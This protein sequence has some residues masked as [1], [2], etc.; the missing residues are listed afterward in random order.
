MK[1]PEAGSTA[2]PLSIAAFAMRKTREVRPREIHPR[3]CAET[4]SLAPLCR[5]SDTADPN[6]P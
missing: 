4:T 6:H 5:E 2:T 3:L 1:N